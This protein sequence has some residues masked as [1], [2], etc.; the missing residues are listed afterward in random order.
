MIPGFVHRLLAKFQ[1][2]LLDNRKLPFGFS[3]AGDLRLAGIRRDASIT[4][5][6]VGANRGDFAIQMAH[7]FARARIFCF[8]PYPETHDLLVQRLQKLPSRLRNR[9]QAHALALGAPDQAGTA[10]LHHFGQDTLTSLHSST[11]FTTSHGI[12][13]QASAQVQCLSG[14]VFCEEQGIASVDLLKV[15]TEGNDLQVLTGFLP[16]LRAGRIRAV[17]VEF[18]QIEANSSSNKNT[19][20]ACTDLAGLARLLEPCGFILFTIHTDYVETD[21]G[22]GVWNALFVRRPQ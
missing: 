20:S 13:V 10:Q 8:E 4:V 16:L 2:V 18:N 19:S 14:A 12:A 15:D 11:P 22:F 21:R 1:L 9:L 3:I 5:F 6:D 7:E 17:L